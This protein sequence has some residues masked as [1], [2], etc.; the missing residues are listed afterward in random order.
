LTSAIDAAFKSKQKRFRGSKP[1]ALSFP[2]G[3]PRGKTFSRA[4][5]TSGRWRPILW[6]LAAWSTGSTSTHRYLRIPNILIQGPILRLLNLKLQRQL[7]SSVLLAM[8]CNFSEDWD[9]FSVQL[10]LDIVSWQFGLV[11]CKWSWISTMRCSELL[12]QCWFIYYSFMYEEEQTV[13]WPIPSYFKTF[14]QQCQ[15]KTAACIYWRYHAKS[16]FLK[17]NFWLEYNFTLIIHYVLN[18]K[19]FFAKAL[20]KLVQFWPPNSIVV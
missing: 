9:A 5:A 18:L 2:G 14:R 16:I 8:G 11:E 6:R 7:F 17:G 15:W 4:W 1:V 10:Q 20:E 12:C 3:W 13:N 19:L